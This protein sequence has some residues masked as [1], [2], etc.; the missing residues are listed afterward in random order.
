MESTFHIGDLLD[1]QTIAKNHSES[2]KKASPY[3][4]I[5]LD[6]FF[7]DEVIRPVMETFPE[8]EMWPT[9]WGK[10]NDQF[11]KK[12]GSRGR[13]LIPPIILHLIDELNSQPF[14][15]FLSELTGIK[16]LQADHE[17]IGAGLHQILR[18]GYLAIHADFNKAHHRDRRLN[19]LVYL[20][21]NWE[22]DWGGHFEMWDR[23]MTRKVKAVSPIYNRVV[24]FSTDETSYHGHPQ[25]LRCPVERTRKSIAL[26]YYTKGI[27]EDNVSEK[28]KFDYVDTSWKVPQKK[29]K[30]F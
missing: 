2:Y 15:N 5:V 21:E 27:R 30:I 20:N 7:P 18:E 6:N 29:L 13:D 23:E 16:D 19:L 8:P 4:H 9:S 1:L 12:Y 11:Q 10:R 25:P 26:Y 24:V 3:P 14:L 17:L 22:E 28:F